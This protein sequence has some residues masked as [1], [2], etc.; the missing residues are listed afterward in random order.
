VRRLSWR[1]QAGFPNVAGFGAPPPRA[2][3]PQPAMDSLRSAVGYI[4]IAIVV[5]LAMMLLAIRRPPDP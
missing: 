5:F 2:G 3:S 1:R 4:V